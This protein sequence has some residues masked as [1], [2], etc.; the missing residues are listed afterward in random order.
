MNWKSKQKNWAPDSVRQ[1]RKDSLIVP[2]LDGYQLGNEKQTGSSLW[3]VCVRVSF[4]AG[5]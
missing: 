4:Y 2:D 5:C 1:N 3:F